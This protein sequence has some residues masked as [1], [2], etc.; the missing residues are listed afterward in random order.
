MDSYPCCISLGFKK[1]LPMPIQQLS[2]TVLLFCLAPV[3][4][5]QKTL[6]TNNTAIEMRTKEACIVNAGKLLNE[7]FTLMQKNYYRKEVVAWDSLENA[8]RLRLQNS[9][10][11]EAAYETIGW[12]FDVMKEKHSFIMPAV[13]AAEYNN[14]TSFMHFTPQLK[15]WVG[16][17]KTALLED[18]IAYL[19]VPWVTTTDEIIC[20]LIADSLQQLIAQYD[21][22]GI[23][24]WI[25]DLRKNTGG[26][27]W[28]MLA[29]VGPLMGNGTCG[30]F[31]RKEDK[32]PFSYENGAAMQGKYIRCKTSKTGYQL[33]QHNPTIILLTGP[34]TSSSGEIITLAF[35]GLPNTFVYG[36]PTAGL[37]TANATYTLSNNAQLVLTVC[38]EAD[39]NG[40]IY[41]GRLHPDEL[42]VPSPSQLK[43]DIVK[44]AAIM[45]LQSRQ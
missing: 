44:A 42:I 15:N 16:E 34:K 23:N 38:Q 17:I 31:V 37:T 26:N 13:K 19:S 2:F 3:A 24:K 4:L 12:C 45:F 25:I 5:A 7:V 36:E 6:A 39:R 20:T 43:E 21:A 10:T 28:P 33:Q 1:P 9:S 14:D 11:C 41:E 40:K 32:V 35:K 27:C 22:L 8:A 18:E 30:F 29:G